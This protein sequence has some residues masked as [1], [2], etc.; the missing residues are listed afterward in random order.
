MSR[1]PYTITSAALKLTAA[2]SEQLAVF[3]TSGSLA[4]EALSPQLRREN[5]IRTI[6]ASLAIENNTLSLEQVTD[7]ID[8]KPVIG[9]PRDIQEVRGAVAAY[10]K[11]DSWKPHSLK[12]LLAAHALLMP[13]LV[14]NPGKLRTGGVGV[15]QGDKI[16]HMAPPAHLVSGH[17]NNLLNWLKTTDEHSLITSCVFHYEFEFIHPFDDGNGRMGR[18]WQTLILS[19][20]KPVLAYMPVETIVRNRQGEY[21]ASLG[22]ADAQGEATKFIEFMLQALHDTLADVH[23][24]TQVRAQVTTQVSPQVKRLLSV[25]KKGEQSAGELMQALSLKSAK[26]FR[27]TSLTPA[28]DAGL[29]ERTQPDSP[30]SPTQR[31]RLTPVIERLMSEAKPGKKYTTPELEAAFEAEWERRPDLQAR[32]R[33]LTEG[34]EAAPSESIWNAVKAE[35]KDTGM[36]SSGGRPKKNP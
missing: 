21:Y 2:I 30:R 13:D 7:I 16:V 19:K 33:K 23:A 10:E 35:F 4:I 18:L 3:Q 36:F 1:P 34:K 20:W 15:F 14:E 9:P 27:L 6:H 32:M 24:T 17:L 11:L 22:Q 8:G 31:Y 25:L 26:N 12:D 29:V 5:R 28:L